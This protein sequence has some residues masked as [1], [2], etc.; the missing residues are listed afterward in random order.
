MTGT[1]WP[2]AAS[3]FGTRRAAPMP[4]TSVC[5]G[6]GIGVAHVRPKVPK[7]VTVAMEPPVASAGSLRWRASSTSSS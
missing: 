7:L 2:L 4:S 6:S 3:Q 5:S 1:N